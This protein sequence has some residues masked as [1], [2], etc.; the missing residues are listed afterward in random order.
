MQTSNVGTFDMIRGNASMIP[1]IMTTERTPGF[2]NLVGRWDERHHRS[3]L[4]D[5]R[6]AYFV[7]RQGGEPVGFAILRDWNSQE[8][9]T[10][11]KRVAVRDPGRGSGRALLRRVINVVFEE[12]AVWR[13]WLGVFPENVRARRTYEAVGFKAEGIARGCAFLDGIHRDE[14]IMALL[15][16]EWQAEPNARPM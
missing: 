1:F 9:V 10:L 15:R 3:A 2:E 16:P 5:G 6:H 7:A 11:L 8:H 4:A 14:L 13:L 12:T